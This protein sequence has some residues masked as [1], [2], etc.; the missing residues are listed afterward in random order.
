MKRAAGAF[1]SA[2][3][4]LTLVRVPDRWCGKQDALGLGLVFFPLI[5]LLIGIV[6]AGLGFGLDHVLPALPVSALVVV[7]LVAASRG[8]HMDG[9]ADT[10]DGFFSSRSRERV[11]EIM[12]DSRT[13]AMGVLAIASVLIVKVALLAVV[14]GHDRWGV[15]LLMPLSGRCVL[16][17]VMMLFPYARPEGGLASIFQRTRGL[18]ARVAL[19]VWPLVLMFA[20]GWVVAGGRGLASAGAATAIAL[21]FGF[22]SRRKVGGYTGDT[23]GT[24]CE[25][26]ELAPALVAAIWL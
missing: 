5:G 13:G 2:L 23:L 20:V 6:A 25:L 9:L 15:I 26:A 14:G 18:G 10:A 7:A 24:T 22:Y 3:C 19:A 11:L 1:F 8:L 17:L 16:P 4:F 12:R 21:L